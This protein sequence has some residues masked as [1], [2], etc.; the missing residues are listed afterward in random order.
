MSDV[1][2]SDK[3]NKLKQTI[4]KKPIVHLFLSGVNINKSKKNN[5]IKKRKK[6]FVGNIQQIDAAVEE[7][8]VEEPVVEEPVV[9]EPVVEEPVVEEPVVEEPVVEEPVVEEEVDEIFGLEKKEDIDCSILYDPCTREPI[10]NLKELEKRVRE[11]KDKELRQI[12]E[13]KELPVEIKTRLDLLLFIINQEQQPDLFLLEYKKSSQTGQIFEAY[14]D[15]VI[16]LGLLSKYPINKEFYM[17]NGNI[18]GIR[19]M[20]DLNLM[21]NSLEYLDKRNINMG[22]SGSSDI[23]LVYKE[24][25]EEIISD[26]CS[27][28]PIISSKKPKFIFC[29]SKYYK[30]DKSKGIDKFD[31]QNIYT[32]AK[33]LKQDYDYEILLLVKNRKIV[34][35]KI[36]SAIRQ[37][38]A[39]EASDVF[40]TDDLIHSL[41]KIYDFINNITKNK[42]ITKEE[43]KEIMGYSK[44]IKPILQLRLHQEIAVQK[45]SKSIELFK[46]NPN[47]NNKFLVGILPRGGKTYIAGGIVKEIHPKRVVVLLGAMSET[48]D[49]F[50]KDLFELFQD[51]N[52]YNIVSVTEETKD[53]NIDINKKY[54]F[55]MS[56]ELFRDSQSKRVILQQLKS[57]KTKMADLYICDEAHLKQVTIRAQKEMKKGTYQEIDEDILELNEEKEKLQ[58][59][60]KIISATIP[61]VYMTGTYLKPLLAF[62]IPQENVVIWDYQD[63]QNAKRLEDNDIYFK[64]IY[65]TLYTDILKKLF[66]YGET[67]ESISNIYKKFPDL[68]LLTT[69]FT[70]EAKKE[71]SDQGLGKGFTTI[72]QLFRLKKGFSS[73]KLFD[74]PHTWADGFQNIQGIARLINYL[75]PSRYRIQGVKNSNEELDS[76]VEEIESVIYSIDKIS[77]RIGDRLS[78]I[79]TQFIV[80]TQ[81]WFIGQIKEYPLINRIPALASIIFRNDWFIK[82][83]NILAVSSVNHYFPKK[84]VSIPSLDGKLVGTLIFSCPNKDESL[85][86]CILREE[87]E[88]RE[89]N[90]GLIILA[91]NMLQV[92]ISLPCA[93]IIVLLDTGENVDERIQKMFR[94]LTESPMKKAGYIVDMNYFRTVTAIMEYQL[95][96]TQI[97]NNARILTTQEKNNEYNR[98]LDL[99]YIDDDKPI[100]KSQLEE[101]ISE[102]KTLIERKGITNEKLENAGKHININI[103]N[104]LDSEYDH[105]Y[106]DYLERIKEEKEKKRLIRESNNDVKYANNQNQNQNQNQKKIKDIEEEESI[107]F[108]SELSEPQKKEAFLDIFRTILKMGV[109]TTNQLTIE[110]LKQY[111]SENMDFRD[112]VYDTLQKR[113]NIKITSVPTLNDRL[114]N[115]YKT[116][117]DPQ[118]K[119]IKKIIQKYES[120]SSKDFEDKLKKYI[121]KEYSYLDQNDKNRFIEIIMYKKINKN[122]EN[123]ND[124]KYNDKN[125]DNKNQNNEVSDKRDNYEIQIKDFLLNILFKT[126]GEETQKIYIE[127]IKELHREDEEYKEILFEKIII[128]NLQKIIDRG[129][130]NSYSIMKRQFNKDDDFSKRIDDVLKYINEHLAP[131]DIERHKYGEV[132]TPLE[133]VDEMLSKLPEKV[134]SNP[135]LKWLDPANGIGNFPIKAFLGQ[136]TGEYTYTGLF[137]GLKKKIPDDKKR[138]KHIIENM[139]FMIDINSK[140]NKIAE[141]LFKKLCPEAKP[142]IEQID[143][144]NGFLSDKSLIFN[145]KNIDKFDIIMGNPPFNRGAVRTAMVTDKTKKAKKEL[146]LET[147]T[148]ESGYW[149]RFII[150]I[151]LEHILKKDGYL[152]FIHPITWFKSDTKGIHDLL[153]SK[154]LLYIRIYFKAKAKILFGGKGEI[155]VAY[156][157]LEN[158]EPYTETHIINIKGNK[159]IINNLNPSSILILEGNTIYNK[160]IKKAPLFGEG[161]GLKHKT[162][163]QCNDSGAYKLITILKDS[164]IIEY[165]QSSIAHPDQDIPKLI[166]GGVP[167][168][169][170]LYDKNGEYGLYQ[171]GQRHYFI[172]DHLDK[173]ND[174]FKTKLSTYLLRNVKYEQ[175]FIKPN[176]LPDIRELDL[177]TINDITLA[178][179]FGF[180]QKER[181][182]INEMPYPIHPKS[183]KI[184]KIKCSEINKSKEDNE[185]S[186]KESKIKTRKKKK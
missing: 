36:K 47:P 77:Q 173:I 54:I 6:P 179:Y 96:A 85:K 155:S 137:N 185:L 102:V 118:M 46:Q 134:W 7:P 51:F 18:D 33:N 43:L 80:H 26:P 157:L 67:L 132:F 45:I 127:E 107:L 79:S 106:N 58:E 184:I 56:I 20:D 161:T 140:N 41:C 83:F 65:G 68:H 28:N 48:L 104:I 110:E 120:N 119:K 146:G 168:P 52:E 13:R 115:E 92:G 60:D 5:I 101:S 35:D 9:E 76:K 111:I 3:K 165:V 152:L 89:Q 123:E 141:T 177:K 136:D 144:K 63:L 162:I 113:G 78:F 55:I 29:S 103:Y 108:P 38:I 49:Q 143:R 171:K 164:G 133:L 145:K 2:V 95:K 69:Q 10:A 135:D 34:K 87:N 159:E 40:G 98:F 150:K 32:A 169:I 31:L 130:D 172:G 105:I 116:Y 163:Q 147:E 166:V 44:P 176:F 126:L 97:K 30:N 53:F 158:K 117:I 37:Y 17:Y 81:I 8:V 42:K 142:N 4:R 109:F 88:A 99:Y 181:T 82:H 57:D 148:G 62:K 19:S 24:S 149:T 1:V 129:R 91:Q 86:Q 39:E 16:S 50:K 100:L 124:R 153:L 59:I 167:K 22:A 75:S 154:Q 93:D 125:D 160:V 73:L 112:I 27:Y 72:N 174:F 170:I 175:G 66:S 128:P 71:F 138:C 180:T 183:D 14:W 11:L 186:S 114:Y 61:I 25:K 94:A 15:I 12:D 182:E 64:N 70:N 178:D 151:F 131:K 84:R 90:K 23:T 74:F 21:N 139:L 122:K 156:Y 121:D